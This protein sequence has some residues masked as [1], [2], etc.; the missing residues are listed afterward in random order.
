MT[1]FPNLL[2]L[3]LIKVS[4]NITDDQDNLIVNII[5]TSESSFFSITE[6]IKKES[7]GWWSKDIK[8]LEIT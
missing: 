8:K 1:N 4:N 2:A 3:F 5:T 6:K 7:K